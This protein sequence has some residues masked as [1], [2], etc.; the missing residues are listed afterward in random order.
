MS[1]APDGYDV[2]Q[3]HRDAIAD[4]G[5]SHMSLGR[6]AVI[7]CLWCNERFFAPTKAEAVAKFRKHEREMLYAQDETVDRDHDPTDAEQGPLERGWAESRT[8]S[9]TAAQR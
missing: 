7:A 9:R 3:W 6:Q 5:E 4:T 8:Y 2:A 1:A